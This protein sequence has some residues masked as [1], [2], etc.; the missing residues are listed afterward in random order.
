[1]TESRARAAAE[2]RRKAF[3]GALVRWVEGAHGLDQVV[4]QVE[5]VRPG[6]TGRI[7]V[8]H[9]AAHGELTWAQ[10]LRHLRVAGI[11]QPLAQCRQVDAL[12][13]GKREGMGRDERAWRKRSRRAACVVTT[14]PCSSAG[15]AA[16][17]AS[18]SETMSGCG[19]NGS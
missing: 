10:N 14:I 9:R 15:S 2:P 7:E 18:R 8:D 5:P 4:E 17:V 16:S 6:R 13:G 3:A 11:D 1:M 19:E 12:A